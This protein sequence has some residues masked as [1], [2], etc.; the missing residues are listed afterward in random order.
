AN[1]LDLR[2]DMDDARSQID[3]TG[4]TMLYLSP[5]LRFTFN[6]T[7]SLGLLY[8]EVVWKNLNDEAN[9]QGGEGLEEYRFIA[10]LSTAF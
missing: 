7:I 9:Q 2:K 3:N 4:G 10:T 1:M 8:K 6:D 5:G